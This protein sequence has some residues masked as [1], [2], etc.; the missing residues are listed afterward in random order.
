MRLQKIEH[1][2]EHNNPKDNKSLDNT[3]AKK[4]KRADTE[5]QKEE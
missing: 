3:M 2:K 4:K 1:S 5:R